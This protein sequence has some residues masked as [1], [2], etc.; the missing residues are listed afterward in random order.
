MSCPLENANGDALGEV[1]DDAD[2]D[3][4]NTAVD[5][6]WDK[7]SGGKTIP[8][9]A[10]RPR[11]PPPTAVELEKSSFGPDPSPRDNDH[12]D[13]TVPLPPP[14]VPGL[15]DPPALRLS[16]YC[17]SPCPALEEGREPNPEDDDGRRPLTWGY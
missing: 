2:D 7:W 17:S 14:A 1:D 8:V 9:L 13:P 10:R 4:A 11:I 5:V 6:L 16:A 3:D 15:D 12:C